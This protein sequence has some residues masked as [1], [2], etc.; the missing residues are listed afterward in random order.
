MLLLLLL[1]LRQQPYDAALLD[2][3]ADGILVSQQQ[4][5]LLTCAAKLVCEQ[6][7]YGSSTCDVVAR[8]TMHMLLLSVAR[9]RR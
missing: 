7:T 3:A 9:G 1:P 6:Q 5:N 8:A 4:D 2:E